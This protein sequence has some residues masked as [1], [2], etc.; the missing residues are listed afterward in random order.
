MIL[1]EL[2]REERFRYLKILNKNADLSRDVMTVESTE[3]P[4]VEKYIPQNTFLLMTGMAFQNNPQLLCE[5]LEALNGHD[6]AGVAIKLGRYVDELDEYVLETADRLQIPL[7]QIPMNMTLGEVYHEILSYIWNNQN[8]NFLNAVNIQ[9]NISSLILRGSSMKNIL[10]N[11]TAILNKPVMAVDMFG[12]IQDYGYTFSKADRKRGVQIIEKLMDN[13]ALEKDSYYLY[14]EAEKRY[15]IYPIKGIGRNTNYLTVLNFNPEGKEQ[16]VL[17]MELVL[18]ALGLYFYR[19]LYV[20]YS[21]M[22]TLEEFFYILLEQLNDKMWTERQVLSIGGA[23]GFGA[24]SEYQVVLISM[25]SAKRKKFDSDCFSQ[26]EESYILVYAWIKQWLEEK[27]EKDIL[28]FPQ[29]SK[30]SYI[31]LIQGKKTELKE[32]YSQLYNYVEKR[33]GKRITIAQGGIVSSILNIK[34]S[35]Q[36]AE[37]CME[38]GERNEEYSYLLS[39]KPKNI[40]ELFKFVPE[41]ERKDICRFTL[42]ELAFPQNQM[43]EELRKTLYTY[44]F[45]GNSITKTAENMFLHRNTIKYRVKKCEEILGAELSSV[46]DCFHLQLA[47][48]LSEYDNK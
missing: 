23:Y 7:F 31:L 41:R 2:L 4:D 37:D 29:E 8:D 38:N 13:G 15:C 11:L 42:K 30:W 16:L 18:M 10:N 45:S 43:Q 12:K 28:I 24:A 32:R 48:L 22:K 21:H 46:S 6:C 1:E 27:E 9:R 39:Y 14:E 20:Q 47:L 33:F 19:D 34:N 35:Y 25:E 5:F 17:T 44:L 26:S 36:E 3:T 40:M